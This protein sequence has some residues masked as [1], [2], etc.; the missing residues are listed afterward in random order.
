MTE[1]EKATSSIV[2]TTLFDIG[3]DG[4]QAAFATVEDSSGIFDDA[5]MQYKP[6]PGRAKEQYATWGVDDKLPFRLANLV[7]GSLCDA[8]GAGALA[9]LSL[10]LSLLVFVLFALRGRAYTG[11]VL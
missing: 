9:P 8:L 1:I 5:R 4:V 6:V 11:A 10:C 7:G 2:E 3:P